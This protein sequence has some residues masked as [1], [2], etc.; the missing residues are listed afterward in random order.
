MIHSKEILKKYWGFSSFKAPQ[1]TVITTVLQNQDCIALLPTGGGKSIC[2]QIPALIKDGVCLVVSPLIA[3]IQDQVKQLQQKGIKATTIPFQSSEDDIVRLFDT[4]K[5]SN[6]K[7]LYISPE[8]LQSKLIQQKLKELTLSL[9]AVDEAHCISE[10]GHDFRPAYRNI[11]IVNTLFPKIPTIALTATA[12]KKVIKDI[13]KVLNLHEPEIIKKSFFKENLGYHVLHVENKFDKLIQIFTKFTKPAIVYVSRR[14]YTTEIA[15][16]LNSKNLKASFYH[17][18]LPNIEKETAFNKWITEETP[19]MVATNAF[20]MG[21]DKSN[22][23]LVVHYNLPFSIENYVQE[24]GRAGRDGKEAFAILLKNESDIL[25]QKQQFKKN[26]PSLLDIKE[27]HK[28]LYQNFQIS[29]GEVSENY[30]DFNILAFCEKYQFYIPI[31]ETALSVLKNHR[32]IEL[33]KNYNRKSSI[34]CLVN[35]R[36]LLQHSTTSKEIRQFITILLRTYSG[37]FNNETT[38]NE[39]YLANKAGMSS[40][41][42]IYLLNQLDRNGSIVYKKANAST[43]LKF[44]VPRE[45]NVT[46]QRFSNEIKTFLMQKKTKAADFFNFINNKNICRSIQLLHYFDEK[47]TRK[48]GICD[49]CQQDK[50]TSKKTTVNTVKRLLKNYKEL[51]SYEISM[52]LMANEK[53]ILIHLRTLLADEKI[54]ITAQNKYTLK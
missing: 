6:I 19:I 54:A 2:F 20:G 9:I 29:L 39:F 26:L 43:K 30:F 18:G 14:K 46:I 48:C 47:N 42:V 16:F 15:D 53:D 22:I 11:K 44:L 24:A 25:L 13:I 3:L 5:F 21:I 45:D 35:S 27:I 17:A 50:K 28:K 7:F 8:R 32:I 52:L 38:I 51:S 23:G 10:W 31:V 49:V 1:E 40:K 34:Q 12:N 4:I 41:K 33:E 37:L 36:S